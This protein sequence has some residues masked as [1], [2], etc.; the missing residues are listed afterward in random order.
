MQLLSGVARWH[1][2]GG[3]PGARRLIWNLARLVCLSS[4]GCLSPT[5]TVPGGPS[6]HAGSGLDGYWVLHLG[7]PFG[8][9]VE[10]VVVD[11]S[12]LPAGYWRLQSLPTRDWTGAVVPSFTTGPGLGH[13]APDSVTWVMT[14]P[15]G[16]AAGMTWHV[17][18]DTVTGV[19]SGTDSAGALSIPLVGVRLSPL[20]VPRVDT[21]PATTATLTPM[22]VIRLDD[23]PS[24]DTGVVAR[25]IA[26]GL[27]GELAIPT[28]LVPGPGRASWADVDSWVRA[29]FGVAAHS[30]HHTPLASDEAFLAEVLGSMADLMRRGYRT[31]VF[32]QPGSWTDSTDF[33]GPAKLRN[34]RGALFQTFT[35]VFEA[36]ARPASVQIPLIDSM[37]MGLGHY[38][39][40]DGVSQSAVLTWWKQA[41][42]NGRLTV[43]LIHS[44]NLPNPDALDWFFDSVAT[45]SRAGR[46][47]VAPTTAAALAP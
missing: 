6:F 32:V 18:G 28:A 15:G 36:Y 22:V 19:A 30:Q 13:A 31:R 12:S 10:L 29:G 8:N 25:M 20:V 21:G 41:Q 35:S 44:A 23:L 42:Q 39:I 16:T 33:D 7:A 45:A 2:G 47:R 4:I 3:L 11:S 40:S 34:W 14:L 38:T 46:V 1:W 5:D 37:A 43:F 24:A 17:V 27:V 26:R 9:Q